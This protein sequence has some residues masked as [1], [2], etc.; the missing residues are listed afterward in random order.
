MAV[1][2]LWEEHSLLRTAT[3]THLMLQVAELGESHIQEIMD[4]QD[5]V[6]YQNIH[7]V[8]WGHI[9]SDI[10]GLRGK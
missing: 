2:V 9:K 5:L 6:D 3:G 1:A 10:K 4:S 8:E 7:E